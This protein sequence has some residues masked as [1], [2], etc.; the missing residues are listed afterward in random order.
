M[1]TS[2]AEPTT[3]EDQL[4]HRIEY[5]TE[6]EI[7]QCP[8]WCLQLWDEDQ[9]EVHWGAWQPIITD[10]G[11][12]SNVTVWARP[13]RGWWDIDGDQNAEDL[14]HIDIGVTAGDVST[15][16][17]EPLPAGMGILSS[18]NSDELEDIVAGLERVR[19]QAYLTAPGTVWVWA[20]PGAEDLAAG[21]AEEDGEGDG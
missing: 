14:S 13:A 21:D 17:P 2:T 4:A 5:L 1:T 16:D 3:P 11:E 10:A 18:V 8:D 12:D 6:R 20:F 15:S 19:D 9:W 7:L